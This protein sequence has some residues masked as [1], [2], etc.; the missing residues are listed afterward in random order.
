MFEMVP[1]RKNNNLS[2]RGDYFDQLFA[3]FFDE[4]LF[5]QANYFGSSMKV[6]L[7]ENENEY[8]IEADLPGVKKEAIDIS[9]ENNY[10]TISAKR[11]DSTE[12]NSSGY[13]RHERRYGDF[14]RSFYIDDIDE[15]KVNASFSEGVLKLNLP[16]KEETKKNKRKF[17]IH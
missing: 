17:D 7:K 14:K 11:D 16:K 1:F 5:S 10:L 12:V 8:I 4:D 6:D 15:N 3:N 9:Y 13:L 2:K